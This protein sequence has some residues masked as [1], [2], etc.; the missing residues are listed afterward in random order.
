VFAEWRENPILPIAR[1][2]KACLVSTMIDS[3]TRKE[4]F[5]ILFT[6]NLCVYAIPFTPFSQY[7]IVP[8]VQTVLRVS[9]FVAPSSTW[10]I[11][12]DY[13]SN[14]RVSDR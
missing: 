2:D 13:P 7:R 8:S 5:T 1:R 4:I 6:L 11:G 9:A 3:I 12:A 10:G 14:A